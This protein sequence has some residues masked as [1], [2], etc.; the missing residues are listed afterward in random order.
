LIEAVHR[1]T[2]ART[3]DAGR[4]EETAFQF[5][6]PPF[7]FFTSRVQCGGVPAERLVGV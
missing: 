6:V 7:Q 4:G 3:T 2:R 1:T 5:L